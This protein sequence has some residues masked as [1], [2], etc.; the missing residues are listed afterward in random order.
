[1]KQ[2]LI[3]FSL[4]CIL[5]CGVY[6]MV[7]MGGLER[8]YEPAD[9]TVPVYELQQ[10]PDAF[11]DTNADG[12][13][14]AIVQQDLA[15]A[16]SVNAVTASE[17]KENYLIMLKYGIHLMKVLIYYFFLHIVMMNNYFLQDLFL[18]M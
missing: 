9:V 8:T 18:I 7:N 10:N 11:D 13:A 6:G 15:K 5:L 17:E 12:A 14:A 16:H 4:G 2:F 3:W 1:M